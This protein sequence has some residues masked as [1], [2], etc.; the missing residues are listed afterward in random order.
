MPIGVCRLCRETKELQDSHLLPKALYKQLRRLAKT[1]GA[2]NTNPIVITPAVALQTSKQVSDYL[3]CTK[4]ED[5]LNKG[6]EKWTVANC[7]WSDDCF[8]L[9]AALETATPL[10]VNR[11]NRIRLYAGAGIVGVN[12]SKLVHFAMGV[13]WRAAIHHWGPIAG[14]QP[15]KLELGPYEEQLRQ[16]V[17]GECG[18]PRDVSLAVSVNSETNPGANENV[19]FPFLRRRKS[20]FRQFMFAI[21]GITFQL[22]VGKAIPRVHRVGC[23]ATSKE[24][25]I[26][27]SAD[28]FALVDMEK[29]RRRAKPKGSIARM[30]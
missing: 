12:I 2:A 5:L 17:L 4:C 18:F 25:F 15:L 10:H 21:P 9:R 3:L 8:P 28:H 11:K 22:F 6:G 26:Y 14:H 24:Q 23:T 1:D 30:R 20:G 7:W 29:L 16:F 13:F 27:L 19:L